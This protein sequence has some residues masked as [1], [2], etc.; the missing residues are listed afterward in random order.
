MEKIITLTETMLEL[1][2]YVHWFVWQNVLY[3]FVYVSLFLVINFGKWTSSAIYPQGAELLYLSKPLS[4]QYLMP[5][6][7]L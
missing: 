7:N 3:V 2:K 6:R 1:Q 4:N 5:G